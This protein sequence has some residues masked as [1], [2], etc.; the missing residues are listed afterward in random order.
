MRGMG[1]SIRSGFEM[2]AGAALGAIF[3]GSMLAHRLHSRW[4]SVRWWHSCLVPGSPLTVKSSR[5]DTR[6][7]Q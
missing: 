5:L 6:L 4:P 2:W 1:T 3:G 7:E